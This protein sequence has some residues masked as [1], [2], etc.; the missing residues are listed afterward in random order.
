MIGV[1]KKFALFLLVA[2]FATGGFASESKLVT[3]KVKASAYNSV[4]AQT[5]GDPTVAAWGD[6]LKP[7]MKVIAVSKDLLDEQ[8]LE[9]GQEVRIQ[10]LKGPFVVMDKMH[11]RW[12]RKIDIYMGNDVNAALKWGVRDVRISYT[13]VESED[14]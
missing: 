14:S 12:E 4:P 7:G 1:I 13:P 11:S 6:K 9:Y 2:T 3:L 10:G 8:G 5:Q